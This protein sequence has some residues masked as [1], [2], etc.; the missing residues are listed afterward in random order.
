MGRSG[1]IIVAA[2]AA[3]AAG[4]LVVVGGMRLQQAQLLQLRQQQAGEAA[5]LA[6]VRVSRTLDDARQALAQAQ[7]IGPGDCALGHRRRMG[8]VVADS[9]SIEDVGYFRDGELVCTR[10]GRIDPPVPAHAS[11]LDLG[12]GTWLS[13]AEP[14]RLF[15]GIPRVELRRG[16]YGVLIAP[17]RLTDLVQ[18]EGL[19][20]GVASVDGRVLEAAGTIDP[21]AI[22]ALLS[23]PASPAAD[24]PVLVSRPVSGLVAFAVADNHQ[25]AAAGWL[26]QRYPLLAGVLAALLLFAGVLAASR[27]RRRPLKQLEQAIRNRDFIVHYQPMMDLATGQCIGAEALLRWQQAGGRIAPPDQFIPLAE[28]EG[29]MAPLTDLLIETVMADLGALLR[30]HAELHVSINI[31]A[32]DMESGHFLPRLAEEVAKAGLVPSQVWLEVTEQGFMDVAAASVAIRAARHAG[33]RV[34]IDDFGTGY[35]SLSLLDGLP[36][37][38]LKIDKSFVRAINQGAAQSVVLAHIISMAQQLELTMVAEGVETAEQG[39]YLGDAGVQYG[40]GWLYARAMHVEQFRAFHR[41]NR[42]GAVLT[43]DYS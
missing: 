11:D 3:L 22:A 16:D 35:S 14:P 34:A 9:R 38:A 39:R 10:L 2:L 23:G 12:D 25:P 30:E 21:Q 4:T 32:C 1:I 13:Y 27:H 15:Q 41:A 42:N 24:A 28:A 18:G 5:A 36:L 8:Q 7:S 40:Q 20:Y 29:L 19:S 43:P 17:G 33:Y 6:A 37:D 26:D 31:A